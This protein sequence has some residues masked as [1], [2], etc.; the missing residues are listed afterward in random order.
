MFLVSRAFLKNATLC[1]DFVSLRSLTECCKELFFKLHCLHILHLLLG[2]DLASV[3][4]LSS[5]SKTSACLLMV[6]VREESTGLNKR[7]GKPGVC[8]E[9]HRRGISGGHLSV[10]RTSNLRI[11]GLFILGSPEFRPPAGGLLGAESGVH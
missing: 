1:Q 11:L 5:F 8:S 4:H 9:P 6:K 10:R 2:F 7:Q 3:L